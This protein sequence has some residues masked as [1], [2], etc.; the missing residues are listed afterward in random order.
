M[1]QTLIFRKLFIGIA[2]MGW[3]SC[4]QEDEVLI[5]QSQ[6]SFSA[7]VATSSSPNARVNELAY[8]NLIFTDL[9][10]SVD[11]FE[12]KLKS[13]EDAGGEIKIETKGPLMITLLDA[14]EIK[15]API[16][17]MKIH[18]GIYGKIEFNLFPNTIVSTDDEMY[19]KSFLI[20]ADWLG[21]PVLFYLDLD[22][23]VEIKFKNEEVIIDQPKDFLIAVYLDKLLANIDP[24]TIDDGNGDGTIEIGPDNVDGNDHIYQQLQA[25]VKYSLELKDG[26][27]DDKD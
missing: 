11:D 26:K 4:T 10:M 20:K 12:L 2:A 17:G 24:T 19:G 16:G 21:I 6:I 14:G 7:T 1:K 13:S 15:V 3:I 18:N 9:H 5:D 22:T 25:N 27:S 8:G 23:E